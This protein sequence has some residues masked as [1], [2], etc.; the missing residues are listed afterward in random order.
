MYE[1]THFAFFWFLML[2]ILQMYLLDMRLRSA[3][4]TNFIYVTDASME[5]IG[6]ITTYVF[7]FMDV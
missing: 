7:S 6:R 3:D 2:W 5:Y 4:L 1:N